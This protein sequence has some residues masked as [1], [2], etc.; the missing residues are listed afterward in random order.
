MKTGILP[1]KWFGEII[2]AV[3]ERF[4]VPVAGPLL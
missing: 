2:A 4:I 3:M 1:G